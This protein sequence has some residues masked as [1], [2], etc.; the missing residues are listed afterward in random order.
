MYC[1]ISVGVTRQIGKLRLAKAYYTLMGGGHEDEAILKE[2]QEVG[3]D[4]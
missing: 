2:F 1:S 3:V 4:V